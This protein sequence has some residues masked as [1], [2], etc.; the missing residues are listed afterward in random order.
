MKKR[1]MTNAEFR[2]LKIVTSAQ[3]NRANQLLGIGAGKRRL[4]QFGNFHLVGSK[5]V[6]IID[7]DGSI[8]FSGRTGKSL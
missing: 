4:S 5:R 7:R 3:T 2:R 8:L 1:E 6:W